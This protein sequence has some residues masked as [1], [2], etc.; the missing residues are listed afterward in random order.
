LPIRREYS[1]LKSSLAEQIVREPDLTVF[2]VENYLRR[3]ILLESDRS[4]TLIRA[5]E[6]LLH[7]LGASG[8]EPMVNMLALYDGS[9]RIVVFP[10]AKHRPDFYYKEGEQRILLSPAAVDLGGVCITPLEEDF[11]KITREEIVRMYDEVCLSEKRFAQ[12]KAKLRIQ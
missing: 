4:E 2:A 3:C 10:R 6:L 9:W 7:H 8:E 5:L 12:L 1:F 11:R